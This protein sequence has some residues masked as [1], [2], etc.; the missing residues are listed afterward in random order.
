VTPG[1]GGSHAAATLERVP[2]PVPARAPAPTA[3]GPTEA[4]SAAAAGAPA[5]IAPIAAEAARQDAGWFSKEQLLELDGSARDEIDLVRLVSRTVPGAGREEALFRYQLS[6]SVCLQDFELP[7]LPTTAAQVMRLGRDPRATVRDYVGV[8]QSDPSL[9][10]AIVRMANSSFFAAASKCAAL[11]Q[12]IVRIGL[13]EVEKVATIHIFRSRVFRVRGHDSLV[14]ELVQHGVGVSIAAQWVLRRVGAARAEAFLAGLFHDV[15]KLFLLQTIGRIQQKL[16]WTAP[17]ELVQSAFAT[18]HPVVGALVC[19]T[20]ELPA[21]VCEAVRWHHDA[22]RAAEAPISQA[23]YLGNRIVHSLE[24]GGEEGAI[25]EPD[26]PVMLAAGLSPDQLRELR[27]YVAREI[28]MAR[29][30]LPVGA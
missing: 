14:Q 30:A 11:D 12:A 21:G 10:S 18:F 29:D 5:A 13:N 15:G 6:R 28:K 1:E 25:C 20:W 16:G 17:A 2:E 26:D 7:L 3:Q 4:A 23:A 27:G 9:V 24:R 19:G 22:S 8:I